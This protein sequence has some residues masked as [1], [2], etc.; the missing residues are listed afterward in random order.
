M[1]Y[2]TDWYILVAQS[3][4]QATVPITSISSMVVRRAAAL[5]NS[6]RALPCELVVELVIYIY[7]LRKSLLR[8]LRSSF[9]TTQI[10][11]LLGSLG[12]SIR[13]TAIEQ[14]T[15]FQLLLAFNSIVSACRKFRPDLCIHL[16]PSILF[17]K[18]VYKELRSVHLQRSSDH[19]KI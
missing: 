6:S 9:T 14:F 1:W 4:V 5:I 10:A 3:I 7:R 2:M 15:V 12:D 13:V 16:T 11:L 18:D 8:S 19:F 17:L